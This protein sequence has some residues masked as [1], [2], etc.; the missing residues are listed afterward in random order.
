VLHGPGIN[1]WDFA[2]FKRVRIRE[3]RQVN[4]R[5]EFF[6]FFNHAQFE[7]P[8]GSIASVNF[9]RITTTREPRLVQFALRYS[10]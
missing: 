9:G 2:A 6:N 3:G 4:F 7:I 10:F 5:A 1:N 8:N